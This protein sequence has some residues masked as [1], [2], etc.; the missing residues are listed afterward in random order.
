MIYGIFLIILGLLA[1]PK[2]VLDKI[3]GL[4]GLVSLLQKIESFIGLFAIVWGAWSTFQC[5]LNI[6]LMSSNMLWW[7]TWLVGAIVLLLLGILL[8][9][10]LLIGNVISTV[11]GTAILLAL[12]PYKQMLAIIALVLGILTIILHIM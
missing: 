11:K 1:A 12:K 3:P 7:V 5:I 6:S 8:G 4:G 10:N 2:L 9:L